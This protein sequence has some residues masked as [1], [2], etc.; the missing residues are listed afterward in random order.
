MHGLASQGR[1]V[2]DRQPRKPSARRASAS[3]QVAAS[4]GP[5]WAMLSVM[6]WAMPASRAAGRRP[7]RSIKPVKPHMADR[8]PATAPE[9]CSA[10]PLPVAQT[11]IRPHPICQAR[12]D[13][14]DALRATPAVSMKA[15]WIRSR[16][17]PQAGLRALTQAL[18][19]LR[20]GVR[21][22]VPRRLHHVTGQAVRWLIRSVEATGMRADEIELVRACGSAAVRSRGVRGRADPARQHGVGVGRRRASA[23]QPA[24]AAAATGRA[25]GRAHL[26]AARREP[27]IRLL[28]S[29]AGQ[30]FR[31]SAQRHARSRGG[32]APRA[33]W[34]RVD[35]LA[36]RR[37]PDLGA[38]GLRC[39]RAALCRR[40]RG[41]APAR[42]ARL[43]GQRGAG[44][45][46]CRPCRR[47][48]AHPRR[49]AQRAARQLQ[50]LPT[51]HADR[52]PA[53]GRGAPHHPVQQQRSRRARLRRLARH[54]PDAASRSSGTASTRIASAAS[55]APRSRPSAAGWACPRAPR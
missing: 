30:G 33:R 21:R 36:H 40:V 44:G 54:R 55:R 16:S 47:R 5:R 19:G 34:R 2:D 20:P 41:P 15:G 46:L 51:L 11:D 4:S 13:P 6:L 32:S 28:P 45:R 48:A 9:P 26:P 24:H 37:G 22:L 23:R 25:P 53:A 38:P 49:R 7:C 27:R 42:G 50:L 10:R 12:A 18:I 39:R 3:T 1:H 8:F 35:D 14:A 31:T 43:A 29:R 52:L 17:W